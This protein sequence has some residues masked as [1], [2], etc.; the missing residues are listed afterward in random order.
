MKCGSWLEKD[1]HIQMDE[2]AEEFI[3]STKGAEARS[4]VK[5]DIVNSS[6][7]L[8]SRTTATS[9]A[10]CGI[11]SDLFFISNRKELQE[12]RGVRLAGLSVMLKKMNMRPIEN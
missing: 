8:F 3:R 9:L 10:C 12:V 7:K 4:L 1:G 11:E 6:N 5:V 2:K